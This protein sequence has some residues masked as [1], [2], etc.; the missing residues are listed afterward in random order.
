M[1][2]DLQK[3]GTA[4]EGQVSDPA[5]QLR[6]F[7][8]LAG[9]A[10]DAESFELRH[11]VDFDP[12]HEQVFDECYEIW[13]ELRALFPYQEPA[14]EPIPLPEPEGKRIF[15]PLTLLVGLAV[16]V[17]GGFGL[18]FLLKEP[19]IPPVKATG[20]MHYTLPDSTRVA[21]IEGSV[22]IPLA[23]FR[24]ERRVAIEGQAAFDVRRQTGK[25]FSVNISE[26]TV[27]CVSGIFYLSATT[28]QMPARI[29]VYEGQITVSSP[30][31]KL[32]LNAGD[33]AQI[34]PGEQIWYKYPPQFVPKVYADSI[35]R[36]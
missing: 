28:K 35:F 11:W 34:E 32:L 8:Y 18:R 29:Y 12:V 19:L 25:P 14:D 3:A 26:I 15:R 4:G 16:L 10:T 6:I 36:P 22:L 5:E 13:E 9:T 20:A 30:R 7:R 33:L 2:W 31:E 24:S 27:E 21:L 17:L 1:F 23:G